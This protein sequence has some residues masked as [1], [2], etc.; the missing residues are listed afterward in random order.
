[1]NTTSLLD[2]LAPLREPSAI[3]WWPLAPGWW[4]VF[5]IVGFLFGLLGWALAKRWHKNHYRRLALRQI[6]VLQALDKPTLEQVNKL[7]K[8]T[9]LRAWPSREVAGLHGTKWLQMLSTS[10][11]KVDGNWMQSLEKVYRTPSD[12]APEELLLGAAR[13]IRY[14]NNRLGEKAT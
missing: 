12:P 11:P 2:Q 5:F 14:H 13:W 8:A 10:A 3:G 7:L 1:M 9:A 4:L 6:K